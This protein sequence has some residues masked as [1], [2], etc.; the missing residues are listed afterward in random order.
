V[1]GKPP[2][3]LN[4]AAFGLY[5]EG[6]VF[7][8]GEIDEII[9]QYNGPPPQLQLPKPSRRDGSPEEELAPNPA[10]NRIGYTR[11][12]PASLKALS[13][14][15][16]SLDG[17]LMVVPPGLFDRKPGQG[18]PT[19]DPGQ[20]I[21]QIVAALKPGAVLVVVE[22]KP[23]TGPGKD[24]AQKAAAGQMPLGADEF[25]ARGLDFIG[26]IPAASQPQ[27][28]GGKKTPDT[29]VPDQPGPARVFD[30]YRKPDPAPDAV[31]P[32]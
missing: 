16:A 20:F 4:L 22:Q 29:A 10:D 14:G 25:K 21:E 17:A 9:S 13:L 5:G 8:G 31:V 2:V 7:E 26:S 3:A 24:G 30:L 15:P 27:G 23:G 19:D 11:Y 18:R 28:G 1:P 6:D 12:Q 32:P